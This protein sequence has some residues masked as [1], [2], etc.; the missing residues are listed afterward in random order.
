MAIINALD[1]A[2]AGMIQFPASTNNRYLNI[3]EGA[4]GSRT[5]NDRSWRLTRWEA[6]LP[7]NAGAGHYALHYY[8]N[9]DNTTYIGVGG[10]Y[11]FGMVLPELEFIEQKKHIYRLHVV[12]RFK[13]DARHGS[14][15]AGVLIDASPVLLI[16]QCS[17]SANQLQSMATNNDS[18]QIDNFKIKTF[19][20][21]DRK[22]YH[23][24]VLDFDFRA[25]YL[26]HFAAGE[27]YTGRMAVALAFS[28]SPQFCEYLASGQQRFATC[29]GYKVTNG[30]LSMHLWKHNETEQ[31]YNPRV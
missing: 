17:L 28:E 13:M 5:G 9:S 1:A 20:L 15:N 18:R 22:Q 2:N 11:A 3:R 6:Q 26:E 27:Q 21:P 30:E 31:Y 8:R 19:I 25:T 24:D 14:N 16:G 10:I 23:S 7:Q 4:Y 12:G 29:T